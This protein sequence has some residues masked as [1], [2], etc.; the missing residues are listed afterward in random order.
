MVH[1]VLVVLVAVCRISMQTTIVRKTEV[2]YGCQKPI[3]TEELDDHV[4]EHIPKDEEPTGQVVSQAIF[5]LAVDVFSYF[6]TVTLKALLSRAFYEA[7]MCG[8]TC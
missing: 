7:S 6:S 5:A 8:F 3:P 2:C 4:L 1:P